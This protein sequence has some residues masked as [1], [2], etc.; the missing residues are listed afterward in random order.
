MFKY[1]L[2]TIN[3]NKKKILSIVSISLLLVGSITF[4]LLNADSSY[5]PRTNEVSEGAYGYA[6]YINSLR[7]NQHTG[8][9][10]DEDIARVQQQIKNQSNV[11]LK[12][13][14]PLTWSFR[15]P[16]NVGGR[17]RCLVIDKDNANIMYTGG[18]SGG[19]FKTTNKGGSW[20]PLTLGADN[21]GVMSMAQDHDGNLYYG[22]GE[23]GLYLNVN[24]DESSSFNG[25]GMYKSTDDGV[26][27]NPIPGSAA[28]GSIL[29]LAMHPTQ[30]LIFAGTTSGL[31]YSDDGGTTWKLLKAGQCSDIK[32]NSNGVVM[33]YTLQQIYRSA[34]PTDKDSYERVDGIGSSARATTAWSASDPNYC[35]IVK[36]GQ[37][38]LDGTDYFGSLTGMY[39]ST[40]AG[41]TFT[42]EV[43]EISSFFAPFTNI[44]IGGQGVY[45]MCIA[46]HPKNKDRVFIGGVKFAEWTLEAG[47]KIVGNTF[48][49]PVNPYGLH[50]DKHWITFDTTGTDPIMFVCSD[51]G[52][53]QSTDTEISR[54]KDLSTGL[55]TTQFFGIDADVNGRIVGGTQDNGTMILSG[56]SFPRNPA[57]DILGGDGFQSIFSEVNPKIIFAESQYGNLN[58]SLLDGSAMESIWDNRV[59][60]VFASNTRPTGYFNN[61]MYLWEDPA[62]VNEV[63]NNGPTGQEDATVNARLYFAMNDGV[64]VCK[65]A[66]AKLHDP[67]SP[68]EDKQVRWFRVSSQTGVQHLET[69]PDGNSLF[70]ATRNGKVIRID[71]LL[72]AKLDTISLPV[73]NQISPMLGTPVVLNLPVGNRTVT[74]IA[75]DANDPNR[76]VATLGNYNNSSY[77]YV[78]EDALGAAPSFRSIHSNLPDFPV[79][80]AI[81]S[82]DDPD[83]IILGTEFGI[84]ATTNGTATNPTW[85]EALDGK[86]PTKPLPRSPVFD[87][88]QTT[89]KNWSGPR[90]YAGTHGMGIWESQSLLTSVRNKS[91]KESISILAY[92]NPANN[93]VNLASDIKG[94]YTLNIYSLNGT[95]VHSQEG[96]NAGTIKLSTET[97]TNGNYFIELIGQDT[98]AVSKIIVQH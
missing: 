89:N 21:F 84:W 68:T 12:T 81:I 13:D 46:V 54:Y 96:S 42:K 92:P 11:K 49:S 44:G 18:V 91:K 67:N 4:S 37:T 75:I 22:T 66:F 30:N 38:D 43:G 51:G 15:G 88:V 59:E 65:N 83:I 98:K 2:K 71:S 3:M 60:S 95:L 56:K 29:T 1:Y 27:W 52:I 35:Y 55:S 80:H 57:F 8:T 40:D 6:E 78:C 63:K 48:N 33:A 94:A 36:V 69:T 61:P 70:I 86:D 97:F 62:I 73:A 34:T 45:D 82:V 77:V 16:D 58:R 20:Y 64:W 24:G 10:S 7:A 93:V 14:W 25:M 79:Y 90:I 50:A 87:V 31:R 9:V 32:F 47:P 28:F 17:T 53:A 19:V 41:L 39:R 74:S 26:T 5:T 76:V 85:A 72:T 23:N